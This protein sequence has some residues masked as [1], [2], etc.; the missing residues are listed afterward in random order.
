MCIRDRAKYLEVC[1]VH[2]EGLTGQETLG[3]VTEFL[4]HSKLKTLWMDNKPGDDWLNLFFKTLSLENSK[5][6]KIEQPTCK[7]CIGF[8]KM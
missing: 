8:T 6:Q 2:G 1:A 5:R 7:R 3:L 4:D